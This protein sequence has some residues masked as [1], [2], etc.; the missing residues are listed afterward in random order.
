MTLTGLNYIALLIS[1][2]FTFFSGLIWFGPKTF[3]PIWMKA[4]GIS[5]TDLSGKVKPATVFPSLL[6]AIVFQ[7]FVNAT[8]I[9]N[10]KHSNSS[11]GLLDGSVTGFLLGAGICSMPNLGHRLFAGNG[12]KVWLIENGNDIFNMTVVGAIVAGLN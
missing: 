12:F 10:L 8:L 11:F 2:I 3:Y 5:A 1:I 9:T 4:M 7:V 6:L